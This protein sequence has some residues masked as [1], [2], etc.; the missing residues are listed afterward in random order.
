MATALALPLTLYNG[1]PLPERHLYL[2]RS[3]LRFLD[4][5]F[6]QKLEDNVRNA[7]K[8]EYGQFAEKFDKKGTE[9]ISDGLVTDVR[10]CSWM[11]RSVGLWYWHIDGCKKRRRT[12]CTQLSLGNGNFTF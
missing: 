8:L 9:E 6:G 1:R 2:V 12:V 10:P 5:E 7:L 3:T 11:L 4:E